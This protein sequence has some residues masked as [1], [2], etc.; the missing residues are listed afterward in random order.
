MGRTWLWSIFRS[1]GY[2]CFGYRRPSPMQG[3]SHGPQVLLGMAGI[4]PLASLAKASPRPGSKSR[5]HHQQS[6][7][8]LSLL[9]GGF[10]FF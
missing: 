10:K 3:F 7:T 2:P 6:L 8:R 5:R 9:E 1:R 4:Q